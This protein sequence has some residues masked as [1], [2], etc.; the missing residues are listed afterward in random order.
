MR[1]VYGEWSQSPHNKVSGG[2]F[3][4]SR[5]G[6]LG[7]QQRSALDR[8]AFPHTSGEGAMRHSRKRRLPDIWVMD[9]D[10]GNAHPLRAGPPRLIVQ[11]WAPERG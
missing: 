11:D 7:H 6:V 3:G 8:S 5:A 9:A 1:A 2:G 4:I 10:G